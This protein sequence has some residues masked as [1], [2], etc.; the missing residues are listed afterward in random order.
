MTKEIFKVELPLSYEERKEIHERSMVLNKPRAFVA[1]YLTRNPDVFKTVL[2]QYIEQLELKMSEQ[3]LETFV[4][5]TVSAS[6]SNSVRSA[7]EML[8]TIKSGRLAI[9]E[10]FEFLED[11]NNFLAGL[12][13]NEEFIVDAA[14]YYIGNQEISASSYFQGILIADIKRIKEALPGDSY[15]V[16]E[17][18]KSENEFKMIRKIKK[19]EGFYNTNEFEKII[20]DFMEPYFKRKSPTTISMVNKKGRLLMIKEGAE[21]STRVTEILALDEDGRPVRINL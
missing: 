19:E 12:T 15:L 11:E 21:S 5:K 6:L 8:D 3:D 2:N 4:G 1:F 7:D 13:E 9:H 16:K 18:A 10:V 14:D 17:Y 20:I